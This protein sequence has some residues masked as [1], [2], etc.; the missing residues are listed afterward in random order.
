[1]TD[2]LSI[3]IIVLAVIITAINIWNHVRLERQVREL[4]RRYGKR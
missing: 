1:M 4:E 2:V 3:V